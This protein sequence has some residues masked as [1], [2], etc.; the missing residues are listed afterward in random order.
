MA[1]GSLKVVLARHDID[2]HIITRCIVTRITL[3]F[4][5]FVTAHTRIEKHVVHCKLLPILGLKHVAMLLRI[6]VSVVFSFIV[7]IDNHRTSFLTLF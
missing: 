6:T 1:G 2:L 5:I 7:L 3:A 4:A